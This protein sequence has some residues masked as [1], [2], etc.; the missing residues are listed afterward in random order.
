MSLAEIGRV[1]QDVGMFTAIREST[2]AY[3]IL[4]S[5]H[6]ACIA[7]FGGLILVTNLRLLGWVLTEI[8]AEDVIRGLRPWKQAGL[9]VMVTAGG[10]LGASKAEEYLTNPF[11]Q[12]KMLLLAA[13]VIHHLYFRNRVYRSSTPLVEGPTARA[14]AALSLLLWVGVASMGRWIA[15]Y[16][17]PRTETSAVT[18]Q[19]LTTI[20]QQAATLSPVATYAKM[21]RNLPKFACRVR[22]S[23]ASLRAERSSEDGRSNH[24]QRSK[25]DVRGR[26]GDPQCHGRIA[27]H[28]QGEY[29]GPEH[30]LR[31]RRR[32][33]ERRVDQRTP[34]VLG[35]LQS[36]HRRHEHREARDAGEQHMPSERRELVAQHRADRRLQD[37]QDQAQLGD[38]RRPPDAGTG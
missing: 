13:L 22:P 30:H 37:H 32:D 4:L 20:R 2:L 6:L 21:K 26:S 5:T 8:P 27:G 9:I 31:D 1:I 25:D 12:I 34:V 23:G 14:A 11:F 17:P 28:H 7:L 38:N 19:P 36:G 24:R 29:A 35:P 33:R 3:P 16:D 15:Y 10:L 18:L